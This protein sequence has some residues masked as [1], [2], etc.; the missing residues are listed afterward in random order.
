[1]R[2]SSTVLIF[3]N[4]K[5]ALASGIEF[6]VSANNVVLSPGD[7]TGHIPA[8]LFERV[9]GRFGKK[10]KRWDGGEW[11][12]EDDNARSIAAAQEVLA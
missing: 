10:F 1:M 11:V 12:E 3:I 7:T 9:T 5:E 6:F 8:S 2:T 4:V